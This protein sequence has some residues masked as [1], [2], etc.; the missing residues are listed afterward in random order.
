MKKSRIT[1]DK[2]LNI[3]EKHSVF[4]CNRF[5]YR[6]AST[7]KLIKKMKSEGLVRVTV[8][9][10]HSDLLIVLKGRKWQNE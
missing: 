9:K 4:Y 5:S 3:I 7:R 6:A 10:S 8:C 2:I 1:K